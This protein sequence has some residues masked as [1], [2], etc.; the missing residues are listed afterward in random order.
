MQEK[1][2]Q[3]DYTKHEKMIYYA[4]RQNPIPKPK[5]KT[6]KVQ[7]SIAKSK[8]NSILLTIKKAKNTLYLLTPLSHDS[9]ANDPPPPRSDRKSKNLP[10]KN[11]VG[12]SQAPHVSP[13]WRIR[14]SHARKVP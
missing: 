3:K 11:Q 7:K 10:A 4:T 14:S 9:H 5:E 8:K 13:Q 2:G 6:E 12:T 1:M